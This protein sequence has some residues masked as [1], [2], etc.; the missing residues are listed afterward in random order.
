MD[1]RFPRL[2]SQAALARD[3]RRERI[4]ERVG[5]VLGGLGL[6]A[7]LVAGLYLAAGWGA[8]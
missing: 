7:A 6:A 4:R 8:L 1:T 2:T 3:A 5:D